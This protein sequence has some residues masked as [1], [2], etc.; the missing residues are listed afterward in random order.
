MDAAVSEENTVTELDELSHAELLV[1]F[2]ESAVTIRFAKAQQWKTLGYVTTIFVA[3]VAIAWGELLEVGNLR[4]IIISSFVVSGSG[5]LALIIY[6]FWQR[7]EQ[8]KLEFMSRQFSRIF[9]RVRNLKSTSEA[10]LHRYTLLSFMVG[11]L[12][13]ANALTFLILLKF[14]HQ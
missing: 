9:Q 1:L 11:F 6:Q 8:R 2:N 13:F 12:L 3:F 5:I 7:T 4:W 10:N 14:L